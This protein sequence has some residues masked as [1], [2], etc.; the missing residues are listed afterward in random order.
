MDQF[1]L[2]L[3]SGYE[4]DGHLRTAPFWGSGTQRREFLHAGHFAAA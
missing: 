4:M 2:I 1:E 3:A